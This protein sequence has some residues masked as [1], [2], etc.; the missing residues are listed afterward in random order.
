VALIPDA[1]RP[2]TTGLWALAD[3]TTWAFGTKLARPAPGCPRWRRCAAALWRV[4]AAIGSWVWLRRNRDELAVLGQAHLSVVELT[5]RSGIVHQRLQR[6][7]R[8][9]LAAEGVLVAAVVVWA[10]LTGGDVVMRLAILAGAVVAAAAVVEINYT[11]WRVIRR[12]SCRWDGLAALRAAGRHG[13]VGFAGVFVARPQGEGAGSELGRRWLEHIDATQA[14]LVIDARDAGLAKWYAAAGF[15][16]LDDDPLLM[17]RLPK[18]S[19]H[20]DAGTR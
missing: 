2:T 16:A 3:R 9:L 12:G 10:F 4:P 11:G 14:A 5:E 1:L 7:A 19:G 6:L 17:Y 15:V 8:P 18:S 20:R 13:P